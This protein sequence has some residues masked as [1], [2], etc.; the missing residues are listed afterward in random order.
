M[1]AGS[2]T[3]N[4]LEKSWAEV[5]SAELRLL[6]DEVIGGPGQYD[7]KSGKH[8]HI[9]LGGNSCR[10]K[11]EF[12]E[13][14]IVRIERGA[15]F[16]A[17]EWKRFASDVEIVILTG[18][19]RIGREISFS[20]FRVT[21]TWRGAQS[22]V[23]ILPPPDNAPSAPME[24]A[25]HPFMLEFPLVASTNWK[26]TNH[27]RRRDHRRLTLLLNVLLTGRTN[28]QP[29]QQSGLWASVPQDN[30]PSSIQWVQQ[31]YFADFG[32]LVTD[33]LAPELPS[34]LGVIDNNNY[35]YKPHGQDGLGL[36]VPDDLDQSIVQ[37]QQLSDQ[38]REKFDRATYWVNMASR[39]WNISTSLSFAALVSA[40]EAL[41]ERGTTHRLQCPDCN[42]IITHESPGATERFRVFFETYAPGD[43][44]RPRRSEMYSLRSSILHGSDLMKLDQDLAFGWDPPWQNESELH[45][46]LWVL[47]QTAIRRW[48]KTASEPQVKNTAITFPYGPPQMKEPDQ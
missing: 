35:Y 18:R 39:Q 46:E 4:L 38:S 43:S 45:G 21:G 26:L 12:K 48:L 37:Y 29:G 3:E 33:H 47:T 22:G 20:S 9:P 28:T 16:D 5:D 2:K 8:L 42:M 11:L 6:L 36:R 15:A 27:R 30:G 23:Q 32:E 44:L 40:V 19:K 14:K 7:G 34:K 31:F 13:G 41:T 1:M 24:I 10:V 25:E 17:A